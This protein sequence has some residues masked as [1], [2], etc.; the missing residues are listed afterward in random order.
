MFQY[1]YLKLKYTNSKVIKKILPILRSKQIFLVWMRKWIKEIAKR[2]KN[3][4]NLY[5]DKLYCEY[6]QCVYHTAKEKCE[7]LLLEKG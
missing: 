4:T 6:K 2:I 1:F 7:D 5:W 3:T